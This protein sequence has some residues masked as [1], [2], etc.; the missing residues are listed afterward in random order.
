[1]HPISAILVSG[2]LALATAPGDAHG[3][4]G[5]PSAAAA[6]IG[7]RPAAVQD[8]PS[9]GVIQAQE[10]SFDKV[11]AIVQAIPESMRPVGYAAPDEATIAALRE[12]ARGAQ[13]PGAFRA[14]IA[15]LLGTTGLSHHVI[16][17]HDAVP[18]GNVGEGRHGMTLA[19]IEG[20]A[21]VT[22]VEPGSPAAKAGVEPGWQLLSFSG[23]PLQ[24]AIGPHLHAR[25]ARERQVQ[26]QALPQPPGSAG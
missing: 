1:M 26:Q 15:E 6:P 18:D 2:A 21:V 24:M 3:D 12:R 13:D 7:H 23:D 19:V 17:P 14:A 16:I 9:K 11:L 20:H 8:A 4:A 5:T 10:R 22:R 25:S